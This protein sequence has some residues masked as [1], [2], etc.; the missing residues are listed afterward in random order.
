MKFGID[1]YTDKKINLFG[2]IDSKFVA[3]FELYE[4]YKFLEGNFPF[5]WRQGIKHD[6][7]KVLILKR[8]GRGLVNSYGKKVE[9]ETE[10]LYPFL[11][12]SRI[13]KP[14]VNDT[15]CVAQLFE[16]CFIFLLLSI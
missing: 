3:N 6:A 4:K 5:E 14:Q 13:R 2:W 10:F 1:L 11:K 9:V 8:T 7:S 15:C 12:G 16:N